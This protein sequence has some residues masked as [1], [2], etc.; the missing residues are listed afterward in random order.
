MNNFSPLAVNENELTETE[1]AVLQGLHTRGW[2]VVAFNPAE[3]GD[4]NNTDIENAMIEG[5]W[6]LIFDQEK[7]NRYE[8]D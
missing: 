6:N 7:L 4:S 3:V 8:L 5:G 1:L 2:A